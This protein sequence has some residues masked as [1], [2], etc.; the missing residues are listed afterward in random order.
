[1]RHLAFSLTTPQV[2]DRTKTVTRRAGFGWMTLRR[3]QLLQAVEKGQGLK[4]GEQ[5]NK[6]AA[7]RV[8]SVRLETLAAIGP[9]DVRAEGF[10]E[11]P[12][13]DFVAF[14]C[15]TH[16]GIQPTSEVVRIEFEYV[17]GVEDIPAPRKGR[18][19]R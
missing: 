4:K 13:H 14:F 17:D 15:S 10:G 19:R 3:G 18:A 12:P 8:R 1:M 9:D 16:K 7:I 6:L 5:V 11:M 2:L